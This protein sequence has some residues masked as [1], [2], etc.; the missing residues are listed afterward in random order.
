MTGDPAAGSKGCTIGEYPVYV[1]NATEADHVSTALKWAD[2][3]SVRV[4]VKN[5]GHSYPGR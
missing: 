2:Q 5:T 3:Q 4:V 1:V